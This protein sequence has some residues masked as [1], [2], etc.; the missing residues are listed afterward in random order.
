[1]N[2]GHQQ[3]DENSCGNQSRNSDMDNVQAFKISLP[4]LVLSNTKKGPGDCFKCTKK[5]SHGAASFLI[6]AMIY[7]QREEHHPIKA[8]ST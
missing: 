6:R 2:D 4:I 7:A 5:R 3:T 8:V 1:M